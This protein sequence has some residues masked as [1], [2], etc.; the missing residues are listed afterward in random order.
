MPARRIYE[1]LSSLPNQAEHWIG[2]FN[3]HNWGDG[4]DDFNIDACR[5]IPRVFPVEKRDL[6][7]ITGQAN[8]LPNLQHNFVGHIH[9]DKLFTFQGE[10][11][12]AL[13]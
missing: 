12:Q 8:A 4:R 3:F 10:H 6:W 13:I 11:S 9:F 5:G 2:T 7:W 1:K